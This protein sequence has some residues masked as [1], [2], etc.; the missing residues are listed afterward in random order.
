MYYTSNPIDVKIEPQ[1]FFLSVNFS[2]SFPD[3]ISAFKGRLPN[4]FS[5]CSGISCLNPY[6]IESRTQKIH[7]ELE[8]FLQKCSI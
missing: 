7:E 6:A 5:Q 2:D 4:V 8:I 1:N 3:V